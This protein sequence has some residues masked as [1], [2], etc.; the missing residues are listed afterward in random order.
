VPDA[1]ALPFA[2]KILCVRVDALI[3]FINDFLFID[4]YKDFLLIIIIVINYYNECP[5]IFVFA[6]KS[7]CVCVWMY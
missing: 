2:K 1:V 6:Q 5:L 7:L 3:F 4:Y